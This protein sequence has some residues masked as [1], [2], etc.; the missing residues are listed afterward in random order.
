[1]HQLLTACPNLRIL[2][3]SRQPLGIAGEVIWRVPSLGVPEA[4]VEFEQAA[5]SEA[6]RLFLERARVVSPRFEL[7]AGNVRAVAHLCRRLDGIPLALELASARVSLL[8]A[9]QICARLG[10]CK[11]F[12]KRAHRRWKCSS[13]SSRTGRRVGKP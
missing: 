3:T 12:K 8:S 10:G 1:V 11:S 5:N 7:D 9:E 4:A 2:A 6:V 13:R